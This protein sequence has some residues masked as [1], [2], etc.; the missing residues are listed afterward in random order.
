[1]KTRTYLVL[2][3][4][5]TLAAACGAAPTDGDAQE[6]NVSEQDITKHLSVKLARTDLVS[7]EAGKAATTDANLKNAW[8]IA[9]NPTGTRA[10]VTSSESVGGSLRVIDTVTY[11]VI[12][13]IPTGNGPR[14]VAV[15]PNGS[16]VFVADYGADTITQIDAVN[17]KVLRT[18]K[19]GVKPEGFQFLP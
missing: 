19:V 12:A 2:S 6:G 17:N 4:I 10:F 18:I 9:F 5:A 14:A 7:D 16:H 11:S 13:N 1:M 8:G 3:M 15:T